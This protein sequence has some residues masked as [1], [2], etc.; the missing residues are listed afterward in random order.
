MKK[1]FMFYI[2]VMISFITSSI[3]AQGYFI[4]RAGDYVSSSNFTTNVQKDISKYEGKYIAASETYESNY[5]FEVTADGNTL[6]I[7]MTSCGTMDGGEKWDCDTTYF[8]DVIVENGKF[9]L[10]FKNNI[11]GDEASQIY[12]YRFVKCTYKQEGSNK[13][14]KSEGIVW[15]EFMMFG[16]RDK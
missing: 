6:N 3:N 7:R 4:A 1:V 14:I 5:T 16:E 8:K 12:N 15:E 9:T 13:N 2:V 10:N 11:S